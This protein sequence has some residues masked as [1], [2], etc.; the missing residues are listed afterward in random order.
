M[1]DIWS[2]C[3][4]IIKDEVGSRVVE[5]WFKAVSMIQ[6]DAVGQIVHLCAPN[7]FVR[8]WICNNYLELLQTHLC[9]LLHVDQLKIVITSPQK[10]EVGQSDVQDLSKSI[11]VPAVLYKDQPISQDLHH[12]YRSGVVPT[13]PFPRVN[14][15][16][17]RAYSFD[18]FIVGPSNSLSY[19]AA[20]AITEKP[21]SLYNPLFIYGGSGLGKTHL[22]HAIGNEMKMKHASAVVLYQPA[23]RFVSEF[24]HAIRFDKVHKFQSKYQSVDVL[25][26]DDIQFISNKEQTQEAFFHIFNTLYNAHKQ[27]VFSSDVVPHDMNGIAERLRSRLACGLVTDIHMPRLETKIAILKKKAEL[28]NSDLS[29]EIAQFIASRAVANIRELEGALIRVLAFASLMHQP[30]TLELAKRVLSYADGERVK[31]IDF[32]RI[33]RVVAK[34]Y[35]QDL[36]VLRSKNRSKD[37]AFARHVLMYM[38]KKL[39]DKSFRDIGNFLGGR[40]HA[41]VMHALTKVEEQIVSDAAFKEQLESIESYIKNQP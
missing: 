13:T 27:I 33:I 4:H 36:D 32:D 34:Y 18:T 9:R 21:G 25:L 1:S 7:T 38:M 22:L 10:I 11:I 2:S 15:Y 5:T 16:I 35:P 19:A 40:N 37:V 20:H 8:D 12:S 29:D 26:I 31:S 30:V 39:T 24:I 28:S 3:L 23:D 6:W 41:T 14:G 17:N